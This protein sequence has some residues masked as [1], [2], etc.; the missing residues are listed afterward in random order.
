MAFGSMR[1]HVEKH[2][3]HRELPDASITQPDWKCRFALVH[4]AGVVVGRKTQFTIHKREQDSQRSQIA[5]ITSRACSIPTRQ[6]ATAPCTNVPLHSSYP[7][8]PLGPTGQ[9][10]KI[11]E[12]RSTQHVVLHHTDEDLESRH[13]LFNL[14][15]KAHIKLAEDGCEFREKGLRHPQ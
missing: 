1:T 8:C 13:V 5:D 14:L 2:I 15:K 7:L 4:V 12:Y 10:P 3:A 11:W 6:P 9:L